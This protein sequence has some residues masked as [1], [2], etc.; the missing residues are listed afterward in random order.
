MGISL[1]LKGVSKILG[2]TVALDDVSLVIQSN[3]LNG[4]IGSNGAGKTTLLR[5]L[6]GLLKPQS[7]KVVFENEKGEMPFS[8]VRSQIAY[9][10]QEQSLYPDLSCEEHMRFFRDLYQI[11]KEVYLKRREE[12]YR[13][14]RLD[15]FK[16]RKAGELSGGMYKKLGLM[17]V[18]LHSPKILILDEPTIGVDPLSRRELWDLMYAMLKSGM[19]IIMSTSYMDEAQRCQHVHLLNGGKLISTGNPAD[20]L[21]EHKAHDFEEIFLKLT[22]QEAKL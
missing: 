18:L 17:C 14:T 3:S 13:I 2:K 7:G 20:V 6:V 22:K 9:F 10:P 21:K 4:L 16:D 1:E 5:I 19:L 15:R 8:E 11:P 12:L